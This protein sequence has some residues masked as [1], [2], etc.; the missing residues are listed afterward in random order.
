MGIEFAADFELKLRRGYRKL[1]VYSFSN[2][3]S[4]LLFL[5]DRS[6]FFDIDFLGFVNFPVGN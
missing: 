5:V 6:F 2:F 4:Y 1:Y 3:E